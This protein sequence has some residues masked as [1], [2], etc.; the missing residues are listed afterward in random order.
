[1]NKKPLIGI[2]ALTAALVGLAIAFVEWPWMMVGVALFLGGWMCLVWIVREKKT[3]VF[4]D[5]MEPEL[6]ERHMRILKTFLL[7]GGISFA[8]GIL[9]SILHNVLSN[10]LDTEEAVSFVIV[11]VG[12]LVFFI[13]T[14]G[15][16]VILL[17][18]QRR[19]QHK[20]IPE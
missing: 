1:M 5:Q 7:V 20:G 13:A 8:V 4:H 6:A 16:L 14:I 10:L 11:L 3:G 18:G 19:P 12:Y 17:I 2:V 9:G 15:A